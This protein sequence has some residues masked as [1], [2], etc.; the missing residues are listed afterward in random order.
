MWVLFELNLLSILDVL[1]EAIGLSVSGL[2]SPV[3]CGEVVSGSG[4][5]SEAQDGSARHIEHGAGQLLCP[6][7]HFLA[8]HAAERIRPTSVGVAEPRRPEN[9]QTYS[10]SN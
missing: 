5:S 9:K 4:L 10:E 8:Q 3:D 6:R 7:L 1:Y 2:Y